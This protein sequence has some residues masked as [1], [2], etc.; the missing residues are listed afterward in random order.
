MA[1]T[2]NEFGM[3]E[4]ESQQ[5]SRDAFAQGFENLA[6]GGLQSLGIAY[7]LVNSLR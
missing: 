6:S 2:V 4:L 5:A 3:S 7:D 1:D